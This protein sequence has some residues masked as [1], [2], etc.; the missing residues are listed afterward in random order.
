LSARPLAQVL[1]R[2]LALVALVIVFLNIVAV[3]AYYGADRR[4]LEV[5]VVN[6]MVRSI[7]Q[8]LEGM[9]LPEHAPIRTMFANNPQ[10]YAFALINRGGQ[11][12]DVMNPDLIH[13]IAYTIFADDWVTRFDTTGE[14]LLIAGHEFTSR[15]DGL[16]LVFVMSEDPAG[17]LRNAF[18]REFYRHV[19][20]PIV[21]VVLLLIG[22]NA[23]L[24]RRGLAPLAQ[25]AAWARSVRPGA[26]TEP[27]P[28]VGLTLETADLVVATQRSLDEL[29]AALEGET[30]RAA[31]AAH[32]LRTPVAVLVARLDA[33]PPGDTTTRLAS[34]HSIR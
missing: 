25:A 16:R 17:L 31:E 18:L 3:G 30:R 10:D 2:R 11:T 15:V 21:P 20:L 13:P 22:A 27:P 7:E 24:I 32:A 26:Y 12:L 9:H 34:T 19:G 6:Q 33:L 28:V 8:S 14:Y 23:L 29:N 4:A 5:E 1:T